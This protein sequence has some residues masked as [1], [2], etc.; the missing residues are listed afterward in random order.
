MRKHRYTPRDYLRFA[1]FYWR[2]QRRLRQWSNDFEASVRN[3]SYKLTYAAVVQLIPTEACNLRCPFCNQWGDAG[4]FLA[5]SRKVESID[6]HAVTALIRSLSPRY[7]MIN[8]HGGEPFAYKQIDTLLAA[9]A[10]RD[11]DVLI[12]TNGTLMKGHL[13]AVAI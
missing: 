13:P 9:L 6:E 4:Y 1:R 7:S 3:G 10:E 8:V 11:F 2:G 12:T 5:G